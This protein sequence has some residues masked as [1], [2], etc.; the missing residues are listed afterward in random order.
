MFRIALLSVLIVLSLGGRAEDFDIA[1]DAALHPLGES[2]QAVF[3]QPPGDPIDGRSTRP[4]CLIAHGSGGLWRENEPGQPC[5]PELESNFRTLADQL[6]G[7]GVASLLPSSFASRDE[8]FCEDNDI[9]YFQFAGP[10]FF[11]PG[12][13]PVDRDS[14]YKMRRIAIRTLDLLA[15]MRYLCERPDIDCNRLCVIGTSNGGSAL[16]GYAANDIGRHVSE[17]VDT[18]TQREHESS[19]AF[20]DRQLAF[21]NFPALPVDVD[22]EMEQRPLPRFAQAISPG[23]RLRA[24]VPTV[25][26]EDE[27][28]DPAA[29]LDDLFYPQQPVE[30]QVEIGG[31]DDVPDECRAGGIRE[32]QARAYESLAA[33]DP[34]GYLIEI[35]PGADHNLLSD[36]PEELAAELSRLVH[37]HFYPAIFRDRFAH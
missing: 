24:L 21:A 26:P 3:V 36:R 27:D 18:D 7:M 14:A 32:A 4:A 5:G 28:F 33:I 10:P 31:N 6:A 15:G 29:H 8:R 2:L 11:N 9:D 19:S 20:E 17:Y 23:C 34:P 35:Y 25:H 16:L 22:Q 13:G 30:L 37:H 12:D 1:V